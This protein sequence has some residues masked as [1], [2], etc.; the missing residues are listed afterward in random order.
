MIRIVRRQHDLRDCRLRIPLR[1]LLIVIAVLAFAFASLRM[2]GVLAQLMLTIVGVFV[3]SCGIIAF[4][5]R[6]RRQAFSI[7]F[8]IP[9]KL[10]VGVHYA[11]ER[12]YLN[13]YDPSA[14]LTTRS[15][16]PLHD[17]FR[18]LTW[19]QPQSGEAIL[20]FDLDPNIIPE[21]GPDYV[22]TS[23]SGMTGTLIENPRRETFMMVAHCLLALIG[24]YLGGRFAIM[25]RDTDQKSS[26]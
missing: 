18:T 9:F 21:V 26:A 25:I 3:V 13:P 12:D 20:E 10:Y 17:A 2:G 6:D 15:F 24:G 1:E 16:R 19:T 22:Y 11:S 5:A 7:G 14:L 4:V 8:L 23:R